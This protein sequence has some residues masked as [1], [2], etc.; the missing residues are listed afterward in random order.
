MAPG[1]IKTNLTKSIPDEELQKDM[2]RYPLGRYGTPEEVAYAAI[3]LLSDASKW[4]TGSILK[5]DG[6]L[7]LR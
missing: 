3:Y 2:K 7:T 5:I 4:M 1:M 6:G